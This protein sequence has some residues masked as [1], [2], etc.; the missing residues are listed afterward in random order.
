MGCLAGHVARMRARD[1]L[2]S[3][4][5]IL[6]WIGVGP[7]NLVGFLDVDLLYLRMKLCLGFLDEHEMERLE[8]H[9][10]LQHSAVRAGSAGGVAAAYL[11]AFRFGALSAP[12]ESAETNAGAGALAYAPPDGDDS[13]CGGDGAMRVALSLHSSLRPKLGLDSF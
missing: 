13:G 12:G 4:R 7:Q 6:A 9:V 10:L 5:G 2:G 8:L 3:E 1:Q 11:R